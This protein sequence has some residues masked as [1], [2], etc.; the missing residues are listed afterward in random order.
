MLQ[1]RRKPCCPK[2]LRRGA[3]CQGPKRWHNGAANPVNPSHH[4]DT[5]QNGPRCQPLPVPA[6]KAAANLCHSMDHSHDALVIGGGPAGAAT[7]LRLARAGWSVV[8]VERKAFP[9]RKVCGEYL[10]ATNLPLLDRLG[11]GQVFR[12]TAGPPVRRV[13]LFAGTTVLAADLPRPGGPASGWGR[14]LSREQLDTLLLAEVA[15]A[16]VDVRQPW[17]VVRLQ[18]DGAAYQCRAES[19][20]TKS[21]VDLRARVVVAAHGSWDAGALPTQPV[22]RPPRPGDL[23]GFKAHFAGSDLPA[24]L[25]PLLVFPGGYGGMVRCDGGRV[26]LSCCVRRDR[27]AALREGTDVEAG[28]AVL[29][30]IEESCLGVRQALAGAARLGPWLATGPIRPGIRV[31]ANRGIFLVGNSAG[32]AHP[33]VAEGISMALQAAWLLAGRLIAWRRAGEAVSLHV[34]GED[35]AAAWRRSFAPRLVAAS[36]LAHWAMRPAAVA[37]LRPLLWCFPRLLTWGARLSGKATRVV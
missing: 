14:A 32:E 9:R 13:G 8:L 11:V 37:G 26:S 22:R 19:A 6:A 3:F 35:Y 31:R 1:C 23:F 4:A 15:R 7:A 24:D 17:S 28:R 12:Q 27:L 25:M 30:H 5:W 20:V 33:V 34:V 36:V 29:A 21:G 2:R 10:S 16:G 18:E